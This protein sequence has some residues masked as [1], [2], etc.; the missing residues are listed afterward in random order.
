[1]PDLL[2]CLMPACHQASAITTP[3]LASLTFPA[4]IARGNPGRENPPAGMPGEITHQGAW[5]SRRQALLP[6]PRALPG[7]AG[8]RRPPSAAG[9][10]H[11]LVQGRLSSARQRIRGP[12]RRVPEVIAEPPRLVA[13]LSAG[14]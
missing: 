6:A 14:A 12:A 7:K 11:R 2:D 10:V 9:L 3:A 4:V 8:I 1:M 5:A 13:A